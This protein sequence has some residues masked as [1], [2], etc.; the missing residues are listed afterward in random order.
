MWER[1]NFESDKSATNNVNPT[2]LTPPRSDDNNVY[3]YRKVNDEM[4]KTKEKVTLNSIWEL[5]VMHNFVIRDIYQ[6]TIAI[7]ELILSSRKKKQKMLLSICERKVFFPF[8]HPST[9]ERRSWVE[10]KSSRETHDPSSL[11]HLLQTVAAAF[12]RSNV[13]SIKINFLLCLT[14]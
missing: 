3:I 9:K 8:W 4:K 13:S 10:V 7:R 6:H 12:H 5:L 14:C 1:Y 11:P 2:H